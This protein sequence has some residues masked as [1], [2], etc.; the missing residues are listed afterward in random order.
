MSAPPA[1][2][3]SRQYNPDLVVVETDGTHWVVE[4]KMD[5]ELTS[6]EV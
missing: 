4:V 3:E 1:S 6:E 2:S 5:K